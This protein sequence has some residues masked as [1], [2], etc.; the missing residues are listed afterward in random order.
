M[1]PYALLMIA[2][3]AQAAP[4]R[5][6]SVLAG[7]TGRI[8]YA[9]TKAPGS[10]HRVPLITAFGDRRIAS[11]IN[12]A[13]ID[14][15]KAARCEEPPDDH[16]FEAAV[17]FIGADVFSVRISESWFCGAAYPTTDADRSLVFDLRTGAPIAKDELFRKDASAEQIAE[18]VF[19]YEVAQSRAAARRSGDEDCREHW[20]LDSLASASFTYYHLSP[21]GLVAQAEFPHAIAACANQV[22]VPY[23]A[24]ARVAAPDG[25]L[26][27]VIAS[28]TDAPPRY[29]IHR[30]GSEAAKDVFYSSP[31]R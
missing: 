3:V 15:A 20:T 27:R 23:R 22:T 12:A 30:P 29:R 26:S 4:T 18:V 2:A 9:M 19:A 17:S 25:P 7:S 1:K 31:A 8:T 21:D 11:A 5:P 16:S 14:A 6:I 10:R 13:L 28:R 24:L